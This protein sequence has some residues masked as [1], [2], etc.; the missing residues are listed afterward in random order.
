VL[1]KAIG[2]ISLLTQSG[3]IP[4]VGP[5]SKLPVFRQVFADIGD[6]QS[7]EASLST[8]SAHL[9]NLREALDGADWESLVLTDE[10]GSGTDPV[11]GGVL[12]RAILIEL[13]RR[14][15]F[16]VATTHLGQLKLLA[17][18]ERGVVNA[19][20]QFDAERLQ[21]TYRLVK[22][23]PGRSYGLAIARRLGMAESVL[24]HAESA[25]P[26]GER[27][28]A[29]L[30]LDLEAKEQRLSEATGRAGPP[31]RGDARA[32]RGAGGAGALAEGEG[33]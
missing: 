30:L 1:L 7:I 6:E 9:K 10:I 24:E 25:M 5:R 3:I 14:S 4:P 33:A 26:Q 16:T 12:A 22:G 23:I 27:D 17:T 32:A 20:L 21:P 19:S 31:A 2:L 29:R 13:T 28:V 11:E 18:E 15:A 8:F